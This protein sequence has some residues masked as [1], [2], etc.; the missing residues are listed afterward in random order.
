M[1]SIRAARLGGVTGNLEFR[2]AISLRCNYSNFCTGR[3]AQAHSFVAFHL[4]SSSTAA[5]S[6]QVC[7]M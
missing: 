2:D 3:R 4:T 6:A 7:A 5:M 1:H